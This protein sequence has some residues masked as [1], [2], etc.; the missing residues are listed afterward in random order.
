MVLLGDVGQ[1]E[2]YFSLNGDSAN[3]DARYHSLLRT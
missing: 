1:M 3:L 2:A